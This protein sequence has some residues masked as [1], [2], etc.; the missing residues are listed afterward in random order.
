V[1]TESNFGGPPVR[2]VSTVLERYGFGTAS[3]FSGRGGAVR[4]VMLRLQQLDNEWQS[5]AIWIVFG[6]LLAFSI[7][8]VASILLIPI[9]REGQPFGAR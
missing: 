4:N 1:G 9:L 2:C 3:A 8:D 7:P 5:K 6:R